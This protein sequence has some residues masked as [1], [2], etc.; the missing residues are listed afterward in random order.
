MRLGKVKKG[1][2]GVVA[3]HSFVNR[4]VPSNGLIGNRPLLLSPPSLLS[5]LE[6]KPS[7]LNSREQGILGEMK[8]E[9]N[10]QASLARSDSSSRR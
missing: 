4:A 6:K 8:I 10:N 7:S 9:S 1:R 5:S 2:K 3:G